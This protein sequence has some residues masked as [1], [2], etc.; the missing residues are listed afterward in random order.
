M[1]A[2]SIDGRHLG[3][4]PNRTDGTLGPIIAAGGLIAGDHGSQFWMPSPRKVAL[5]DDF[6]GDVVADQWNLLEGTDSSTTDAAILS[7]GIGGVLR[8]T[9]GDAGTGLAADLVQMTQTLNWQ[10]SNG[11]LEIE[12]R[13]KLSRI[14]TAYA[15]IGFTDLAASLEAPI[16]SAASADTFTTNATDA[17]GWMFDTRMSTDNWWLTGVANDVDATMQNAG[18]A[19]VADTYEVL[20]VEVTSGGKAS[21]FRNG[22]QVGTLMSGAL[23]AATDLTPTL[24]FGNTSGTSSFTADVDYIYVAMDRAAA[25]GA[26]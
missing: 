14:T 23:T 19:P 12:A 26:T 25:G 7:G 20:R 9:T 15:F 5:L 10:A 17:V 13:V 2:F 8:F 4:G 3:K 18:T 6:L 11:G 21:F 16:V 22:A 1:R 24:A